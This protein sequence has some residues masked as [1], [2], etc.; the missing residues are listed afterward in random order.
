M[1]DAIFWEIDTIV[2]MVVA[3]VGVTILLLSLLLDDILDIWDIPSDGFFNLESAAALAAG[4]GAVAWFMSGYMGTPPLVSAVVGLGGGLPLGIGSF[5]LVRFFQKNEGSSGFS[6]EDL[7]GQVGVVT[8][9]ISKG[10]VGRI[11]YTK[12][13]AIHQALAQTE[14]EQ[15]IPQGRTVKIIEV[16]GGRAMVIEEGRE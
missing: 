16:I 8:L 6:Q 5:F 1:F 11:Q 2:F 7:E 15:E 10:G 13:G 12:G 3:L 4:F 9:T 14:G